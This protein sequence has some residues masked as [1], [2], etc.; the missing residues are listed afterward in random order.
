M[1]SSTT[2]QLLFLDW[3]PKLMAVVLE[4]QAFAQARLLAKAAALFKVPALFT[5]QYPQGLG[6]TD[7]DLRAD[8]PA[9]PMFAKTTFSALATPDIATHIKETARPTLV[10][11]GLETSICV[12]QTALQAVA[13]NYNVYV[14][15]DATTGRLE[16]DTRLALNRM[17]Q[18]GVTLVTTEMV[19]FEWLGGA[20][21]PHFKIVQKWVAGQIN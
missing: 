21:H 9:A 10:I 5:E 19:L 1:L 16:P 17:A 6:H 14:V 4:A 18:R 3:Q 8:L 7:A 12:L 13:Q 2:S 11:S 15:T 20:S